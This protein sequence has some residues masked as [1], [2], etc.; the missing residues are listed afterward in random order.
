MSSSDNN[1]GREPP[2]KRVKYSAPESESPSPELTV[3]R[4][5]SEIV[6]PQPLRFNGRSFEPV[7]PSSSP[8]SNVRFR[9]ISDDSDEKF[10]LPDAMEI[11]R[12]PSPSGD[13]NPASTPSPGASGRPRVYSPG[14]TLWEQNP[15]PSQ[16]TGRHKRSR[17][18]A[19]GYKNPDHFH[20]NMI[21]LW[22]RAAL[23]PPPS[24]ISNRKK[25]AHLIKPERHFRTRTPNGTRTE[26]I[27]GHS[28]GVLGHEPSAST[29]WNTIG[30]SQSRRRNMDHNRQTSSYHGIESRARSDA[31][32]AHEPRYNSPT[33]ASS[34][35]SHFDETDED[36]KGPVPWHTWSRVP[37]A[38]AP[39]AASRPFSPV[40]SPTT[41]R[42]RRASSSSDKG[43]SSE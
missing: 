20:S 13:E 33:P 2:A 14:G 21:P 5:N 1:N 40:A 8:A 27:Q 38:N 29:H 26:D 18:E 22:E 15:T 24:G 36:F 31:S 11:Q 10:P 3:Q 43:P 23:T 41:T 35:H 16:Q 19:A 12:S 37:S 6:R 32:G 7:S 30:H 39:P 4:S 9:S 17:R 25:K 34:H 42:V 28:Q